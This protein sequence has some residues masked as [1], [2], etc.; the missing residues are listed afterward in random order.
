MRTYWQFGRPFLAPLALGVAIG[1]FILTLPDSIDLGGPPQTGLVVGAIPSSTS[2]SAATAPRIPAIQSTSTSSRAAPSLAPTPPRATTTPSVPPAAAPQQGVPPAATTT[3]TSGTSTPSSA[4]SAATST[5]LSALSGAPEGYSL[6]FSDE[7]S[8]TSL[9]RKKWKTRYVYA[10]ETLDFLNDE[11]QR[12]RDNGNHVVSDGTL[13]LIAKKTRDDRYAAYESGM[14]RSTYLIRYGYIEARVKLPDGKGIWP[15]FW[16]NSDYAPDGSLKWPPEIDIF[17]YVIDGKDEL[18]DM[19]HL[20]V[21]NKGAQGHR[22]T[23]RDPAYN[24]RWGY[25]KNPRGSLAG[26]WH[27]VAALWTE[28]DVTMYLDGKKIAT[29]ETK[30]VYGNGDLAAPA[31]ILLNFGVGG[32]WAGRNGIDDSKFPQTFEIDYVRAYRPS[33]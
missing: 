9:D 32:S 4:P 19:I 2:T 27:K 5:T 23:Y 8:G 31:H 28:N 7:F 16:L 12:Y 25:Y 13:K 14:I 3:P 11:Q 17:E 24:A 6:A 21:I 1:I 26:E 15:A 22:I 29:I 33:S 10:N 18:P 20:G 30:W